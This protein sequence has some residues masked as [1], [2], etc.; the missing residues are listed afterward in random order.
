MGFLNGVE[1]MANPEHLAILKRGRVEWNQ[2]RKENRQIAPDLCGTSL[3]GYDLSLMNFRRADLTGA[4]LWEVDLRASDLNGATLTGAQFYRADLSGAKFVK[5]VL[6]RAQCTEAN[7]FLAWFYRANLRKANFSKS[8]LRQAIFRWADLSQANLSRTDLHEA[9]LRHANLT[10]ANLTN[11]NLVEAK[12]QGAILADCSIYGICA[13]DMALSDKT[14]QEGLNIS[15]P[16]EPIITVDNLE[17]A[18]FIYLLLHN[19]KIRHVI[20]TITS[21][22]VLILGRFTSERKVNLDE[23]RNELRRRDY[24]P[25]LFDF[26]KPASR[27]LTETISI[28]AHMARFVI[29]D[30]T[31]AK[32]IP[33]ELQ[34]IVPD[35][36]S[37][38]VQPLL[39]TSATEYAMFEHLRRYPWVL[40]EFQY[41]DVNDVLNSL[42]TK[43]IDPAEA[44]AR[45]MKEAR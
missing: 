4:M 39:H 30:I 28:L 16:G 22:I 32:S 11:A 29:A 27:D 3:R 23:I 25:V 8:I 2:W 40:E 34:R 33:Q 7:L 38:P 9:D 43:V 36:P 14:Q 19:E 26:E 18:Q 44:K 15:K 6:T 24:L 5:A 37:V 1:V 10:R 21:K 35:L 42:A 45:E 20:D 41:D 17:V 12:L 31:D 13:W